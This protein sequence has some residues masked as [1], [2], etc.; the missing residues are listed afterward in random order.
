MLRPMLNVLHFYINA[1]QNM[2]VGPTVAV[3]CSFLMSCVPGMLLRHFL[4]YFEIVPVYCFS[5]RHH[6]H[7]HHHQPSLPHFLS[8]LIERKGE[9]VNFDMSFF[10]VTF[11][12]FKGLWILLLVSFRPKIKGI[13]SMMMCQLVVW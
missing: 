1:F 10:M 4:N 6:H 13:W 5:C 12:R 7:H 9:G 2:C 11:C 8:A 3:F